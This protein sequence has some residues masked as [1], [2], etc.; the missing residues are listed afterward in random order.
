MKH[1]WFGLTML[2][3]A[4]FPVAT[5]AQD[6]DI[7]GSA[8][9]ALIGRFEGA[10]ITYYRAV[11]LD[12]AA[13]L[14][15][16]QD[17][18]LDPLGDRS[19]PG[20]LRLE[21]G[22]TQVRYRIPAGHSSLE[23]IRAYQTVLTG[24]G[25]SLV[26]SCT[27]RDC[28]ATEPRDPYLMGQLIDRRNGNSTAYFDK[29]RYVLLS[30]AQPADAGPAITDNAAGD[31]PGGE[32]TAPSVSNDGPGGAGTGITYVAVLVGES[33]AETTAY[34]EIVESVGSA[35]ETGSF[36]EIR[37]PPPTTEPVLADLD[38]MASDLDDGRA[39]NLYG[40]AF[41]FDSDTLLPASTPTLEQIVQLLSDRPD[42][43]LTIVGHTDDQGGADY[44]LDL[45][46]RR[47]ESVLAALTGLYGISPDRLTAY[48]QGVNRP[49]ASNDSEEG[50]AQN[51]R[52]ELIPGSN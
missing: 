39:I 40:L 18:G 20:W 47:A 14:Q 7:E 4:G 34:V 13:L 5:P 42:L 28:F 38:S 32:G 51:R 25:L 19:G 46:Q 3:L 15:A 27:D 11:A 45:S 9:P 23:V 26:F 16:P 30:S 24:K 49:V 35:A 29:A 48:G 12:E 22:V 17:Y 2:V 8:D 21:G 41:D 43:T 1:L 52:V 36:F 50:R 6:Q 10:I 37:D 44:N 31:G 33:G